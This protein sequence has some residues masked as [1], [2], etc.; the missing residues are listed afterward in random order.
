MIYALPMMIKD[1]SGAPLRIVASYD[2]DTTEVSQ[3]VRL[4]VSIWALLLL[5]FLQ[6]QY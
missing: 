2:D 1:G 5:V 4:G 6:L 3:G